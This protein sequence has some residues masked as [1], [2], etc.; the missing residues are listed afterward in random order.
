MHLFT[1]AEH[2]LHK[3]EKMLDNTRNLS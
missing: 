1:A 2:T 3:Q